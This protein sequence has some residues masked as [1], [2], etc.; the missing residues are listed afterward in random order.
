MK[1]K[2]ILTFV[3]IAIL[4]AVNNIQLN[5]V[6]KKEKEL[7]TKQKELDSVRREYDKIMQK[8]DEKIDLNAIK[9]ELEANGL[10]QTR[11]VVYF[12]ASTTK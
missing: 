2:I 6:S 3:V 5:R 7:V 11:D 8:Y 4:L 12:E 1:M 9:T 10:H